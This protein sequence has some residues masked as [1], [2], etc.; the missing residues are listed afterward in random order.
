MGGVEAYVI[1]DV[2]GALLRHSK[3]MST[4]DAERWGKEVHALTALARRTVRDLDPKN[5]LSFFRVRLREK[6]ILAAPGADFLVVVIQKWMPFGVT[7]K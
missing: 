3:G 4:D 2:N 5:E 6:E 7:A 1:A